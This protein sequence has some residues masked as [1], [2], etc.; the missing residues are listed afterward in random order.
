ML[1]F[2]RY[3]LDVVKPHTKAGFFRVRFTSIVPNFVRCSNFF[4]QIEATL[5]YSQ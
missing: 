5:D 4:L 1:S 3:D 2:R